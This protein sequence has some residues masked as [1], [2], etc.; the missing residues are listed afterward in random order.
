MYQGEERGR[1]TREEKGGKKG[2]ELGNQF[3]VQSTRLLFQRTEI[4][5]TTP[6]WHLTTVQNSNP[7]NIS[8]SPSLHSYRYAKGVMC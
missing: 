1:E 8:P 6:T 4:G 7:E 3:G 2:E 5:L